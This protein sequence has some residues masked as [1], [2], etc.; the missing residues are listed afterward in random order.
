MYLD[1]ACPEPQLDAVPHDHSPTAL[2]VDEPPH[3]TPLGAPGRG[4]LPHLP[5]ALAPAPAHAQR[6]AAH[7]AP[8][9][10][11]P[12]PQSQPSFRPSPV[13]R[14]TSPDHLRQ[15]G[16]AVSGRLFTAAG[17]EQP[18]PLLLLPRVLPFRGGPPHPSHEVSPP[19]HHS[20]TA[21]LQIRRQALSP[22]RAMAVQRVDAQRENE[23]EEEEEEEEEDMQAALPTEMATDDGQRLL[24][25]DRPPGALTVSPC[26]P[27]SPAH[28]PAH[29][30]L[31]SSSVLAG[32]AI[33]QSPSPPRAALQQQPQPQ[34]HLQ[35]PPQHPQL[36][37][38]AMVML[39]DSRAE[40]PTPAILRGPM[41]SSLTWR[42]HGTAMRQSGGLDSPPKA[43][44]TAVA[45]AAT[46]AAGQHHLAPPADG[47]HAVELHATCGGASGAVSLPP[48]TAAA[49]QLDAWACEGVS[50]RIML[51][52]CR[53]RSCSPSLLPPPSHTSLGA[54]SR[55]MSSPA[56]HALHVH[57][58]ASGPTLT[59]IS[60]PRLGQG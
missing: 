29:G 60:L 11:S 36:A 28:G 4:R 41:A 19:A 13:L 57:S 10:A 23:D 43:A 3:P 39:A 27:L 17:R 49:P 58:E 9:A 54:L 53:S 48:L 45:A 46:P 38:P 47:S 56:P 20:S 26:S 8:A 6:G 5:R 34:Q 50:T 30:A 12:V 35:S 33:W 14:H 32:R 55:Q 15:A 25:P 44:A 7:P 21:I 42:L 52:L 1:A 24:A 51:Q 2:L 31:S 59:G 40:A 37:T 18:K 16:A 22:T